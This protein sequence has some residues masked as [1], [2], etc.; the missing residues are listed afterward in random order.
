M[1]IAHARREDMLEIDKA[2][3][4][5]G[6]ILFKALWEKKDFQTDWWFVHSAYLLPGGGIGHHRHDYCEEIFVTID[7]AAQFTH[8]GRT[9]QIEG[10][11]AVPLRTGETHAVYNHTQLETRWFNFHVALPGSPPDSTDLDDHRRGAPL[12]SVD[13]LPVGRFDRTL[14]E[15]SPRHGGKGEV[16]HRQIWSPQ[17]FRTN[18]AFLAHCLVPPGSS[19]GYHRHEGMEECYVIMKGN[20]R[21]TVDGETTEVTS[22][23]AIANQL[24]GAHGLY[25]HTRDELEFFLVA[26]CMEKGV[27]DTTDL[28]DDLTTR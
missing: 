25:N 6:P 1:R 9:A 19:V 7:N 23:D 2:H 14:L 5:A 26:V 21:M 28:G 18:L 13:R 16:G 22:G 17:D 20:A 8:N 3:G 27:L 15:Y 10:G 11:A 12:E 24:G 4:G